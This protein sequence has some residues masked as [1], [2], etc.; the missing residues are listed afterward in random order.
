MHEGSLLSK[1]FSIILKNVYDLVSKALIIRQNRLPIV[2]KFICCWYIVRFVNCSTLSLVE[3]ASVSRQV[4]NHAHSSLHGWHHLGWHGMQQNPKFPFN[5]PFLMWL[6]NSKQ[7]FK[8]GFCART[9]R[10]W[11]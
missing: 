5:S 7:H 8:M 2:T 3:M 11:L 9:E 6:S 10:T 1:K 4:C